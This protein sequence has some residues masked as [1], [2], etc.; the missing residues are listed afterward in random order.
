MYGPLH[1]KCRM[2]S[3]ISICPVR[4]RSRHYTLSTQISPRIVLTFLLNN[5]SV[6]TPSTTAIHP[7]LSTAVWTNYVPSYYHALVPAMTHHNCPSLSTQWISLIS[8]LG[9]TS[10]R[11]P[12]TTSILGVHLSTMFIVLCELM[13]G[14]NCV[15][16]ITALPLSGT[17]FACHRHYVHFVN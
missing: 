12:S 5:F 11:K 8:P 10:S 2:S 4:F 9:I 14:R 13:N 3:F 1:L 17:V 6:L 15:L 16:F 7:E